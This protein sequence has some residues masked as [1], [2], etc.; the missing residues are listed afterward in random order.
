MSEYV[1]PCADPKNNPEDWFI[2][3]DGRQYADD[4]VLS[5]ADTD[6]VARELGPEASTEEYEE[7]MAA[8]ASENL[9]AALIRRRHARD[10]C[11]VECY[12]RLQC[13]SIALGDTAPKY[14]IWGG[15]YPDQLDQIRDLRDKRQK[16]RDLEQGALDAESH[17]ADVPDTE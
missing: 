2:E 8:K 17:D 12:A 10:K 6:A 14:G 1:T 16:A 11:H 5:V 7:A 3:K 15:Y 4:Q 9:K 13:L